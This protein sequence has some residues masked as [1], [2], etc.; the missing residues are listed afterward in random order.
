MN[1]RER[2]VSFATQLVSMLTTADHRIVEALTLRFADLSRADVTELLLAVQFDFS[3]RES[4][5]LKR[6]ITLAEIV[7]SGILVTPLRLF[8]VFGTGPHRGTIVEA[9]LQLDG[10]I[11]FD[12]QRFS[13]PSTAAIKAQHSVTGRRPVSKDGWWYWQY[14][15]P[16]GQV[17]R[18]QQARQEFWVHQA[19]IA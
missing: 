1:H 10:I 7:Q 11:V 12:G 13:A 15:G 17:R 2:L 5:P 9:E 4:Q 8:K 18:L 14:V 16:D 6:D 3:F 19:R